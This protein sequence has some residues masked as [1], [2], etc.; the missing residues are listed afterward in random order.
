[1]TGLSSN[2]TERLKYYVYLYIDPRDDSVFYV[3]KGKGERALGHLYD[4][5]ESAKVQKIR[6]LRLDG[7]EPRID[8]LVHGLED[9]RDALRVEAAVID[10]LGKDRLTNRVRGWGSAVVGR[11]SL[12]ELVT[13]YDPVPARIEDPVL[14]IRVNQLYRYGLT[15][16]ELYETTRGVW[17]LGKRREDV[18]YALAV[19]RGVVREVYGVERWS[20]AGS[21]PYQT[22]PAEDVQ[23]AGRW[24]FTGEV[25]EPS[26]REKYLGNNVSAYFAESSQNPVKYVNV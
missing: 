7:L 6:E 2:I 16:Q 21:T 14:L 15:G 17:V 19:F 11:S 12:Q 18:R 8:I 3:G 1:M 24:E 10:L 13:L 5:S 25:A 4:V 26:V 20:P 22:R 9:E 23:I